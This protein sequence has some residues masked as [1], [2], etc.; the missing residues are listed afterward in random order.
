MEDIQRMLKG[1]RKFRNAYFSGMSEFYQKLSQGQQ[2]KTLVIACSDSRV[3]PALITSSR[4]GELFVI[5]NVANLVPPYEADS[6]FH[7][8]SSA[9]EYAVKILQVEHIVV[10][11]HSNCGGIRVLME[12]DD[13]VDGEF[14]G[15]WMSIAAAAREEVKTKLSHKPMELQLQACEE[16]ALL[17]SIENLLSF[18]WIR[19]RTE[20]GNLFIHGWYFDMNRGEL[21]NYDPESDS[22][23]PM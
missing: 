23:K 8:V 9:L 17:L 15:R 14:L 20:A 19:A 13:N 21:L 18:P 4:P 2:P 6:H 16:A 1:F 3:D 5:R 7:G 22:F 10:L 12:A 11:G